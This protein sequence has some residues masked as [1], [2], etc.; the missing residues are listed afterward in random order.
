MI[1]KIYK[2][3][4]EAKMNEIEQLDFHDLLR[5]CRELMGL[6]QYAC[7]EYLGFKYPRYKKLERGV[8]SDPIELWEINRLQAFF[9]IPQGMLQ[10]KQKLFLSRGPTDRMEAGRGIWDDKEE[11]MGTRGTRGTRLK[12]DYVR[13]RGPI[14]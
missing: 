11:M 14:E 12:G 1:E 10:M 6:K 7:A 5:Y 4:M 2:Q 9:K 3:N 8:F 13:K